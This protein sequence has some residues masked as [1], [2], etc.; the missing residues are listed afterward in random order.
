MP[1]NRTVNEALFHLLND[2]AGAVPAI[3]SV[4]RLLAEHGLTALALVVFGL[5]IFELRNN[6]R[7]ALSLAT[8][9]V[10]AGAIGLSMLVVSA[11][12][13]TESRPF[14]GDT[15]TVVLIPHAVDNSFPSHH[16]TVAGGL[17]ALGL[18]TWRRW[19]AAFVALAVAVGLAR[20]YVGLH[21]PGDIIG[22][23]VLGT[24]SVLLAWGGA[25]LV[26]RSPGTGRR[27]A[28]D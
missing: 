8:I 22:G 23:F 17:A 5:A 1:V 26:G 15:R 27:V 9:A 28:V 12:L 25:R 11:S 18:L 20:V 6:P 7:R 2:N 3:D 14:V 21:F 13:V 10:A 19:A 4:G 24:G 16:A